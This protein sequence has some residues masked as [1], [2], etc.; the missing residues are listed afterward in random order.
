MTE[1]TTRTLR[2]KNGEELEDLASCNEVCG[3]SA[4]VT[5]SEFLT[6]ST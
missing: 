5:S 3:Y 2:G 1:R 6:S 4:R